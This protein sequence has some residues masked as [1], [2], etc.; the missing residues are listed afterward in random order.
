MKNIIMEETAFL[1]AGALGCTRPVLVCP[2]SLVLG[3]HL[4]HVLGH[5]RLVLYDINFVIAFC[6]CKSQSMFPKQVHI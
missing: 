5:T 3:H 1:H 2:Q 6:I 4:E